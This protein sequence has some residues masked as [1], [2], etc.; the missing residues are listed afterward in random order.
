MAT[1]INTIYQAY[2]RQATQFASAKRMSG[3]EK[4][5]AAGAAK[6]TAGRYDRGAT[7]ELSEEGMA[8]LIKHRASP[9]RETEDSDWALT[10]AWR[11]PQELS[12]RAK[13]LLNRLQEEYGEY[14]FFTTDKIGDPQDWADKG[15]KKYSVIFTNE[16]LEKM[17]AN[18]EYAQEVMDKV[19]EAIDI[20]ED[21]IAEGELSSGVQLK[22]LAISF[23]DD[24]NMKLFAELEKLSDEQEKRLNET[25]EK[26]VKQQELEERKREAEEKQ[27]ELERRLRELQRNHLSRISPEDGQTLRLMASS[28]EELRSQIAS[29]AWNSN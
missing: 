20:A 13:N 24:G 21:L 16:E 8:A 2:A 22:Q 18:E 3:A 27:A 23:D 25:R 15:T 4:G 26:K 29:L 10:D 19:D 12:P 5:S 6:D 1:T 28:A 14:D 11:E 7:V 17:A 9:L